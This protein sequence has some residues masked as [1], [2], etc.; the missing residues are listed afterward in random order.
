ME[1]CREQDEKQYRAVRE[2]SRVDGHLPLDLR[3]VS[4]DER[5]YLRS[6]TSLEKAL[7]EHPEMPELNDPAIAECLRILNQKLDNIIRLL[8]FQTTD[9]CSLKVQEVNISAGGLSIVSEKTVE[10][11]DLVEIRMMLPTAPYVIFY[12]YGNVIK[13]EAGGD[14]RRISMVFTQIDEDIREHIVK[15][16]FERQRELIRK[17]RRQ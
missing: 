1:K 5:P 14:G 8:A 13:T 6:R 9:Y 10:P 3:V 7:T 15:Y 2:Y 17:K 4:E 12:I 11:G 16:V